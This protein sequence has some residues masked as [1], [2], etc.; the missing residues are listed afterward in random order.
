MHLFFKF[1]NGLILASLLT[2]CQS[3]S[4]QQKLNPEEIKEQTG[5]YLKIYAFREDFDQFLSFYA[6]N[7]VV[8]D[9]IRGEQVNGLAAIKNFFNWDD[10]EFSMGNSVTHLVTEQISV[11]GNQAIIQGY[12]MP[13]EYAGVTLGPWRFITRLEFNEALKISKQTDWINY[14]PKVIFND[15]PNANLKLKI[16]SYYFLNPAN[17]K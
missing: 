16:P 10:N 8:E 17:S 5:Q 7:A 13:F 2:A 4:Q 9:V 12:F 14:T 15:S 1:I 6:E 11:T 3:T